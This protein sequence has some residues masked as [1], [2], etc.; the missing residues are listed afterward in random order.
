MSEQERIDLKISKLIKEPINYQQPVPVELEAIADVYTAEPGE[1]VW[2][3]KNIDELFDVVLD[4]DVDGKITVIKRSP[5]QDIELTFKGLNSKKDYVLV[6]DVLNK[7]D[8]DALARRK[9]A[10]TRGMDKRELKLILDAILAP[11]NTYYPYNLTANAG[12]T[13]ASADDLYDVLL[14][15]KH[16]LEDYGD[17]YVTLAGTS[18]K[19][20]IDLYDKAK[21][22][23]FNYNVTLSAKLRELGIDVLKVF[24][25]VSVDSA[26]PET[27]ETKLLAA[28]KFI[29][30]AKN[31]RVVN[32][33]PIS[34]VRRR[35]TPAIAE[36]MGAD[37]DKAQRAIFVG[38]VPTPV[39][40]AG[41]SR[42][43]LGFSVYGYESIIFC[44][45]NPKA[46][47][48]AD[49]STII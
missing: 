36:R 26:D 29:M 15:A 48:A 31:S 35:I 23:S 47:V 10:I 25:K 1:H 24:G 39:V 7:V 13:V 40:F 42:E 11:A 32:G 4:V 17:G 28:K 3:V 5:L 20:A 34:F 14:K 43:V 38:Q 21:A 2:R 44:I 16:A 49:L 8:T 30:V 33:K 37:V 41:T 46:I 22:A 6:E 45:T 12:I 9:E 18:V 27:V 19:E